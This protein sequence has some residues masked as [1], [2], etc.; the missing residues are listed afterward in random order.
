MLFSLQWLTVNVVLKLSKRTDFEF[1]LWFL[2]GPLTLLFSLKQ[3]LSEVGMLRR[4]QREAPLSFKW[5]I[6]CK[7]VMIWRELNFYRE[8]MENGQKLCSQ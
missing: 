7:F 1:W 2:G 4:V 5:V 6:L 3:T 8:D